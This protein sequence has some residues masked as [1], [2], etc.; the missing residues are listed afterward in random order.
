MPKATLP[1]GELRPD[2]ALLDNQ[3]ANV[4]DNVFPYSNTY[5]PIPS[6]LPLSTAQ[7]PSPCT[8]IFSARRK[9]GSWLIYAGTATRLYQWTYSGWTDITNTNA[10]QLPGGNYSMPTGERWSFC[11]FGSTVIAVQI[12]NKPQAVDTEVFGVPFADLGGSPPIA[13]GCKVIGDF[14]FLYG[15]ASDPLVGQTGRQCVQWSGVNNPTQWVIGT[16][17]SDIQFFADMGPVQGV[18]GS[19][20]VGYIVQDR[21]IRSLQFLP[22]DINLIFNFARIVKERGSVSEFGYDT[23]ADVL[24]FL[25][26]DGFYA[27]AGSNLMPIGFEKINDFFLANSDLDRR[28]VVLCLTANKPY[29]LW[30][31]YSS[32]ASLVYDRVMLYNWANQRWATATINVQM[33]A[34]VAAAAID[35]DTDDPGDP[36]DPDLDSTSPD[37][38]SFKYMGGRPLICAVNE[39]GQLCALNGPN[40]KAMLETAEAHLIPGMRAFV[41]E[42][43]PLVDGAD[44]TVITATRERLGDQPQSTPPIQIEI[45]GSASV[46]TSSRLHRFRVTVP[47]GEVWNNAQG[48]LAEAQPDGYA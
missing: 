32:A 20:V 44:A 1:F 37:L 45:T 43:Y 3:F 21:G 9:D 38:D 23:N 41:N 19:E 34:M 7:L 40:L 27:L 22:G 18:A 25:A 28:N 42:V 36:N 17:L 47:Q 29:V 2:L 8:G 46:L 4:A 13:H 5:K 6:L 26:E 16:N 24:Y 30:P 12:G 14:V 39:L 10:T 15:L 35:L 48:V 33:W 11:Q 31:F